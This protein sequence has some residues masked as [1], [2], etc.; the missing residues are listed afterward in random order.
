MKIQ[1]GGQL[2]TMREVSAESERLHEDEDEEYEIDGRCFL[3]DCEI[4]IRKNMHPD[5]KTEA[6]IHELIG[7]AAFD[8]SGAKH[9]L[10]EA[11]ERKDDADDTEERMLRA[12]I[13]VI[14]QILKQ[15]SPE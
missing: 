4:V 12:W 7:H 1:V 8:V 2:W 11:L 13:P 14:H 10:R 9:I 3:D 5:R 6:R 15:W